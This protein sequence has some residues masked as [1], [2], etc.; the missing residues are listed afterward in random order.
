MTQNRPRYDPAVVTVVKIRLPR[1]SVRATVG[2]T[3]SLQV[4]LSINLRA[5]RSWSEEPL[6]GDAHA[7]PL[8]QHRTFPQSQLLTRTSGP[9]QRKR[10]R[11]PILNV[12]DPQT[13]RG[14]MW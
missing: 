5:S 8:C 11:T 2:A 12:V 14:E 13:G 6:R 10:A 4:A 1:R 3:C 9:V 7:G